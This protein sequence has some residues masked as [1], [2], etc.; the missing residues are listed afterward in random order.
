MKPLSLEDPDEVY[1]QEEGDFGEDT[2][3][4]KAAQKG[5]APTNTEGPCRFTH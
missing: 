5:F 3:T 4:H 2:Y 1:G